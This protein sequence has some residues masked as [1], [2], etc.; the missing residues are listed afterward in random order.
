MH[1]RCLQMVLI[2]GRSLR[3]PTKCIKCNLIT[4][5][6]AESRSN[7]PLLGRMTDLK[8]DMVIDNTNLPV[9]TLT[10]LSPHVMTMI[11]TMV[12]KNVNC[13]QPQVNNLIWWEDLLSYKVKLILICSGSILLIHSV[14]DL[15]GIDFLHPLACGLCSID[16]SIVKIIPH[17]TSSEIKSIYESRISV[18]GPNPLRSIQHGKTF[19]G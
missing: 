1:S 13:L 4:L 10:C 18:I 3:M 16:A 9:M 19:V 12:G 5:F 15:A 11:S 14:S 17:S 2:Y 8:I 7:Q 6:D